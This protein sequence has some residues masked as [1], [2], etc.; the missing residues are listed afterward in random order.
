MN[1]TRAVLKELDI[2]FRQDWSTDKKGGKSV[3]GKAVNSGN[4]VTLR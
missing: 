1:A 2:P 3:W 4:V